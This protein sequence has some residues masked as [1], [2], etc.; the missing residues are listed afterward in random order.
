MPFNNPIPDSKDDSTSRRKQS[1]GL[2][3]LVQA[4]KLMQIAF[5]LPCA[6]LIGWALGWLLDR[7]LHTT[8]GTLTGLIF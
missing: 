4:E 8:W 2:Q 3:S 6:A 5:L 7:W 1:A